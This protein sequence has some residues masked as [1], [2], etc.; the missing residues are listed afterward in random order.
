MQVMKKS[1][2]KTVWTLVALS[3]F[4]LSIALLFE[5]QFTWAGEVIL[6]RFGLTGL[7]ASITL[8]DY[9]LQP[10]PPDILVYSYVLSEGD[11]W[12]VAAL[13]GLASVLGGVIGYF[14]G[15]FLEYEGA[16]KFI[17]PNH[18]EQAH[19][20]FENH[21]FWAVLIGALT[22]VPF[23]VI[24]WCAGIFKMPLRFFILSALVTRGPRFFMVGMLALWAT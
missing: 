3:V 6:A 19:D 9:F 8:M 15:R 10:F 23:N 20:L 14:T 16:V 7:L 21:G 5:P 24:C 17:K 13:A 18:Y 1:M 2:K 4:F 12:L 22:P 11:V